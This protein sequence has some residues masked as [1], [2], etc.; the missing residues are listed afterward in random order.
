MAFRVD[1]IKARFHHALANHRCMLCLRT[2][3]DAKAKIIEPLQ[4]RCCQEHV[5]EIE[6]RW[7]HHCNSKKNGR[8]RVHRR[9]R[10]EIWSELG[11]HDRPFDLYE[12][13]TER[14]RGRM[15]DVENDFD[16]D[17]RD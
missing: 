13:P 11:L 17:D 5:P 6:S 3:A 12:S 10:S 15:N 14:D 8:P 1:S 7:Y 4:I 2:V 9:K 16:P